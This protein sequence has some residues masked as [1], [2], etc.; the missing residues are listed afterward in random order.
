MNDFTRK[1]LKEGIEYSYTDKG[2]IEI[3]ISPNYGSGWSTENDNYKINIAV[4]KRIIDY[5]KE[6]GNKVNASD[7]KKFLESIGYK[8]VFCMGWGDI[9]IETIPNGE[10]FR[11]DEYDGWESL[12][13]YEKDEIYEL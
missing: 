8:D 10:R 1:I 6:H 12:V 4:D 5:Y 13:T 7:V 2:E 9:V 3:L 11:I